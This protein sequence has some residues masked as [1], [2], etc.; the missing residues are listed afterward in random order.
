MTA[1]AVINES[2]SIV[3]ADVKS[4]LPAFTGQWN[5]DLNQ[6]WGVGT[7]DFA[8]APRFTL[9]VV[10]AGPGQTITRDFVLRVV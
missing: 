9:R 3:D 2:T 4:M 6:V 5:V 8:F 7:V 1:L 10:G